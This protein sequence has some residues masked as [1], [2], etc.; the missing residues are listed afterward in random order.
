MGGSHPPVPIPWP[1]PLS[2]CCS[3]RRSP[4]LPRPPRTPPRPRDPPPAPPPA[5]PRT[6]PASACTSGAALVAGRGG[7]RTAGRGGG[8]EI[9]GVPI[10]GG[11]EGAGGGGG[12]APPC[13]R[14]GG[15]R[16]GASD[17]VSLCPLL[18]RN[19]GVC[20]RPDSC[21]CPPGFTGKF[22]HLRA[23]PGLPPPTPNCPPDR[24]PPP[25][26]LSEVTVH[27]HHPP[28]AS[29]TIH[30]VERLRDDDDDGDPEGGGGGGGDDTEG[31]GRHR[32]GGGDFGPPP[33]VLAQNRP[34]LPGE[35]NGF[36][37][38]AGFGYCF[39][40]VTDGECS[41]PLPGLR[42]QHV[43]C[44]GGGAAW[45]VH[46]CQPCNPGMR[47][48]PAVEP[49]PKGFRRANGSC[50]DVDECRE[51]GLCQN[52]VCSNSPGSFACLC[53]EG[54]I[55]D[56]SRSSCISHQV[57]SEAK[58]PCF[59]V[60]RDG[61][62]ALPTLRNITRQICCCSRVGKAWGRD[63]LR[64]PP[65]GSEGFHEI[66]PAG[67]GYHYSAS[68]LRYNARP[69]GALLPRVPL[70]RPRA[71][72]RP[73]GVCECHHPPPPLS[74][75]PPPNVTPPLSPPRVTPVT[76]MSPPP[77]VCERNPQ[78]CG[79]GR[80]VPRGGG[81]T[82]VC[83]NGFWLSTQGTHCIGECCPPHSPPCT[84]H[85]PPAPTP[86]YVD[87]CRRS[88]LPCSHGRCENTVG[89]FRCV[90]NAGYRPGSAGTDC[91]GQNRGGKG[92]HR[93]VGW[94]WMG[95][96]HHGDGMGWDVDECAQS[97]PPCAHGRCENLPGSFRCVCNAGFR[98]AT[99]GGHCEDIN[100]C[101]TPTACP[102][103][104]CL[105]TPGSFQCRPCPDGFQLRHGRCADVDECSSAA[106]CGPRGRCTNTEGSFLCQCQRGYR[107]AA[108]GAP[109][110]DVNECLEGDFCFPHGECL[111]ADGSYRCLC[112]QGYAAAP[113]GTACRD[114]DECSRGDV[115]E[116]GR[117]VNTDGAFE[118][119]CP[120][121]FRSDSARK[122]CTGEDGS[123]VGDEDPTVWAV[124]DPTDV[125]EC[126]E[127]G[128]RLCGAQRCQNIP[129]SFR[130]VPECPPGYR[131]RDNE[132]ECSGPVPRCGAHAVCHNLPGSFQCACHQG[133]EAAPHGHHCQDVDEC[134]TLPG[135]CGA[136]RCENVDGSFLCLCPTDG[137]EFDPVTGTCGGG[138]T[139]PPPPG[140]SSDPT[141]CYSPACGV[142]AANVSR[143]QCC[144]AVGWAWG[145]R[146]EQE[147]AC[148]KDGTAEQRSLCPH[149]M[150]RSAAPHGPP[151]DV[152]ECL[153]FAPHLCR[154]GVCIN[155]APGF[156][157]Y[158]PTGYYYERE[159]LQCVDNDECRD[160][161][162]LGPCVGG[163]CVNTV[164]SYY[165][166]CSPPLVLDGAQRRCVP[167]DTQ[168]AVG[169]CWQEVGPDLV[170]GRP[171]L[172]RALPYSECCCLYGA[173]W[174]MDCALCPARD[175]DDFE[176]LCNALRPP[177]DPPRYSGPPFSPPFPPSPYGLPYAPPPPPFT[178]PGPPPPTAALLPLRPPWG[179]GLRPPPPL[180]RRDGGFRGG[181]GGGWGGWPPPLL[182][183]PPRGGGGGGRR[184]GAPPGDALPPEQCGVLSGCENGRCVRIPR[185]FTCI[186]NPGF[187]LHRARMACIDID[188]CSDPSLCGG[189]RCLNTLGS[190]R[191]FCPPGSMLAQSPPR[192]IPT[193]PRA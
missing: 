30:R 145:P 84:Q 160:E 109:C 7:G 132:D 32:G 28:D 161:G 137:H 192:C 91:H 4:P 19:G 71:T 89:S 100:E 70:S 79:P 97:P 141:M 92:G 103:Q 76:P 13:W 1:W 162:D 122:R 164:G 147:A 166:V 48:A 131:L 184:G 61:R 81:Y 45:G 112:A 153:M 152:D 150:G 107:A 172:D 149:G 98:S 20:A 83:H 47:D 177:P 136:A 102:G 156:S 8:R 67:A 180:L 36:G 49:C 138:V 140:V 5:P 2:R 39:N 96:R 82:C 52:G 21:L 17:C 118:C 77:G 188:E 128:P 179:G 173:A 23:P 123:G 125:D 29:V 40:S 15:A 117:C 110:E 146:C 144:C 57:L 129:G 139:Q 37:P 58:A 3:S 41:S 189:G 69:L 174:G 126:Q 22:C 167:N 42:T 9:T 115:C 38:T 108:A 51:G 185:G 155:A 46:E 50:V 104:E 178:L 157:C 65:Y 133:Y 187:R 99:H 16:G 175:S 66:C 11:P 34:Q 190:F 106:P 68:D 114:V 170:C 113:D 53:H 130:C 85:H 94:D 80:C 193:R 142:L 111:N 75:M 63:C 95:W 72:A 143:Q 135:V 55:L 182:S 60:L 62:C 25:G 74:P 90:C 191:C 24:L 105:N 18:C 151:G 78:L 73:H 154:G 88:P 124:P 120:A 168:D 6:P 35:R 54:F 158:C 148:P 33:R 12:T 165:C 119:H 86:L 44:R 183:S 163:R 186:C 93:G 87:E 101:E 26:V 181:G 121:G 14:E 169:L 59:R 64:C 27:V 134:A 10:G 31:G 116:G 127:H 176:F 159:H 56:S 171:R 43:C